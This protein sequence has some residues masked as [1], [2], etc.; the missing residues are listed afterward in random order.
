M[1]VVFD[2]NV[3]ISD[4][5]LTSNVGSAVRFYL[6]EQ[7]ARIGL[8]EVVRLETEFHLRATLTDHIN[9]IQESH[10]QLLAVFGRLKEV[11]LPTGEEVEAL[12]SKV[13]P[14]LGVEIQEFPFTLES[15]KASLIRAVQKLPPSDKN[16]Q[17]KDGVLWED[18]LNMLRN[19][20]VYLVT[21]D[22]AFYK[23]RE[24]KLG[25][26]DEFKK[27]V[28]DAPNEFR[29]FPSLRDLL[30]QIGTG[31]QI[32]PASLIAAYLNLHGEKMKTMADKQA[33]VLT[34][35]PTAK[36]DVFATE[37]PSSLYI[38]FIIELP[39]SDATNEGR[40]GAKIM[41]RGEGTYDAEAKKFVELANRG[42]QLFYQLRDGTEKK[43]ENYVLVI[44]G[45][46]IGH[47][48]VEHSVRYKL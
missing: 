24:T 39:C 10:R 25:L 30:S 8:P 28:N 17:F 37:K 44:G 16:Q 18:C 41:A 45:D 12:V 40:T 48:T 3:W 26:A 36:L 38:A 42:E 20:P 31:I 32:D 14:N 6:R 34:G 11:V 35:Q 7:K 22:R 15:A 1:I 2:T 29:I 13:F 43:L 21:D 23:N 27:D 33:F 4:L 19:E 5:A 9:E 47:R 46:V